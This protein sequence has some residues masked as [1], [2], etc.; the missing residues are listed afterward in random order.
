MESFDIF[1]VSSSSAE[2]RVLI[3]TVFASSGVIASYPNRSLNGMKPV[4]LETVVLW[5]HTTFINSSDHFPFGRLKSDLIIF[6]RII[7]FARS[8]RPLDSGCLIDAKCIFVPI[9]S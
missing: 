8:T 4:D 6:V 5:F 3:D 2:A 7:P 1:Q 9:W